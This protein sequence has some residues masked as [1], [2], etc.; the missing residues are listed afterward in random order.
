[1]SRSKALSSSPR[2][3]SR[4][5]SERHTEKETAAQKISARAVTSSEVDFFMLLQTTPEF[6]RS[7]KEKVD[8]VARAETDLL[9]LANHPGQRAGM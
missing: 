9:T 8:D 7:A 4:E 2:L 5:A 3:E 1:M 6:C